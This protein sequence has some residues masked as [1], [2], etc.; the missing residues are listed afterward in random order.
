MCLPP[1]LCITIY[2]S[3]ERERQERGVSEEVGEESKRGKNAAGGEGER[4]GDGGGGDGKGETR[5]VE[6]DKCGK[7]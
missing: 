1:L 5:K 7:N 6:G 3:G 4:G 2:L